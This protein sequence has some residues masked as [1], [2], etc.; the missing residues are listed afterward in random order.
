MRNT[1]DGWGWVTKVLHWTTFLLVLNQGVVAWVMLRTPAEETVAGL[2]QGTLYNWHKSIG[3]VLFVVVVARFAWRTLTPLPEWAPN[4]SA[5]E[6]R[7]IHLVERGLYV[8]LF[9]M[10]I[11]GFVFVMA[12]D[13]GVRFFNTWDL[14]N[15]VG[16]HEALASMAQ[17]TH[18]I[19]AW[20]LG[21]AL[22]AHWTI[23]FGHQVR[24]RDRYV[25]RMLPFTRQR[26]GRSAE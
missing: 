11:S 1:R 4:L 17:G 2:S 16:P 3:L 10:P 8:C 24:H 12:G 21:A 26:H 15:V 23:V 7:A 6:K 19:A 22:L 18:R 9:V 13:F 20:L 25:Q 5:R 14:P